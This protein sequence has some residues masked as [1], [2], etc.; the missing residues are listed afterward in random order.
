MNA[1]IASQAAEQEPWERFPAKLRTD[2]V[3]D[4]LDRETL[5]CVDLE[6]ANDLLAT[7]DGVNS[8]PYRMKVGT[9]AEPTV[10]AG[11]TGNHLL[12]R[13]EA[14]MQELRSAVG[15]LAASFAG[16]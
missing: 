3:M 6:C 7:L 14:A 2:D 11:A 5:V 15:E 10:V 4:F 8:G 16:D 12:I 9:G 13:S 1:A